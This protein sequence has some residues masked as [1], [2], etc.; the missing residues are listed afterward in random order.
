MRYFNLRARNQ[1][2]VD[3]ITFIIGIPAFIYLLINLLVR[4]TS[5]SIGGVGLALII[6]FLD[7]RLLKK[8]ARV[9]R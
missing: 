5:S 2:R 1:N 3:L 7:I 4:R 8:S 6:V 9:D